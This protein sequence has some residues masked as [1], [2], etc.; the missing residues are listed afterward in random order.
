[1][2]GRDPGWSLR[3]DMAQPRTPR[4]ELLAATLVEG[5]TAPVVRIQVDRD[6][7][8]A[9]VATWRMPTGGLTGPVLDEL[10][11]VCGDLL[12][13]SLMWRYGLSLDLFSEALVVHSGPHCPGCSQGGS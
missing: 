3:R 4:G 2:L 7:L 13:S 12:V 5:A 10:G 8:N 1:V 6:T 11:A 9:R